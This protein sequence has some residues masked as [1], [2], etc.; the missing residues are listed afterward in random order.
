MMQQAAT[1]SLSS[2]WRLEWGENC[3]SFSK[4]H[5][6]NVKAS[7]SNLSSINT[8]FLCQIQLQGVSRVSIGSCHS[9]MSVFFSPLD[10]FRLVVSPCFKSSCWGWSYIYCTNVSS[11]VLCK[12]AD[13]LIS[14]LLSYFLEYACIFKGRMLPYSPSLCVCFFCSFHPTICVHLFCLYAVT[15]IST[16]LWKSLYNIGCTCLCS[17]SFSDGLSS[18]A[19]Q[20]HNIPAKNRSA[21]ARWWGLRLILQSAQFILGSDWIKQD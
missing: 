16:R 1:F 19:L 4:W 13:K 2:A 5:I 15:N 20:W 11:L 6:G 18:A 8:F 10:R 3:L 17:L 14:K 21:Q 12:K 9:Y 7:I